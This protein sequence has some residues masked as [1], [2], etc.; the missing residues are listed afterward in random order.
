MYFM[1][2]SPPKVF[3]PTAVTL[4]TGLWEMQGSNPGVFRCFLQNS[5]KYGLGSLRKTPTEGIH[6]QS[7]ASRADNRTYTQTPNNPFLSF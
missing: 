7:Q 3:G 6:L 2:S 4:K 1:S 5:R